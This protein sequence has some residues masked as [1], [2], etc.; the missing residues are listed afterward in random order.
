V[1]DGYLLYLGYLKWGRECVKH[2]RGVFSFAV[3]DRAKNSLLLYADHF[4]NNCL[5][6]FVRDKVVY[7]ST[8]LFP[9]VE[10]S[11]LKFDT[12]DRWLLECLTVRGPVLMQEPRECAYIGVYK[13][14]AGHYIEVI[15][16]KVEE[17][18][19]WNPIKNAKYNPDI[20][21]SEA[22]ALTRKYVSDSVECCIRTS[23]EVAV[24]L[25]SGLDST[26]VAAYA[27]MGLDKKGRRLYG[28]TSVPIGKN[29]EINTKHTI[30]DETEGVLELCKMYPN[31]EPDFMECA[32]K[33]I[34]TEAASIVERWELPCMS[35]QNGVWTGEIR[36]RAREKNCKIMLSGATGN[37]TISAGKPEEYILDLVRHLKFRKANSDL[38]Y[39]LKRYNI[40]GR[41][42]FIK[43]IWKLYKEYLGNYINRSKAKCYKDTVTRQDIAE[44]NNLSKRYY[45]KILGYKPV[46]KIEDIHQTAYTLKCCAQIGE[47]GTKNCLRYGI[48]DRDPYRNV[49]FV[50]F[51]CSLPMRCFVD[52]EHER[53][54]IR[55]YMDGIIPD[56]I[57]LDELR[58][59]LQSSDNAYRISKSWKN[60]RTNIR[61][62]LLSDGSLKYMDKDK[63]YDFFDR[64]DE[65]NLEKCEMDMRMIVDAYT[66]GLFLEK[67]NKYVIL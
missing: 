61:K 28:F 64:I 21:D 7:F 44:K 24:S 2:Y 11:G 41:K 50:E 65:D 49:E 31:I 58:R 5:Y 39:I 47:I 19:Y 35:Q 54:L 37:T 4:A 62:V 22:M 34:L 36:K 55:G 12:N 32:G 1:S 10:A 40:Y 66:F 27:A 48:L 13:V 17:H 59:G 15:D 33:N 46:N 8:M 14:P 16:G 3:Y 45:K 20:T 6:Y 26:T 30:C 42:Y 53:K 38:K 67:I 25:S 52:K 60:E 29:S 57:R 9:I 51:L 18:C 63:I 23:G 56:S 43:Y